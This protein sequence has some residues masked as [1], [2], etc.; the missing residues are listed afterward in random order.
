MRLLAITLAVLAAPARAEWNA[1]LYGGEAYTPRSDITLVVSRPGGSIDHTFHDVRWNNSAVY[2][3]RAGYW[4]ASAPWYGVGVDVFQYSADVPTQ[5]VDSTIQG[6]P[7]RATLQPIDFRITAVALDVLRL[8]YRAGRLEPY[9]AAGPVLFKVKV[10]NR[11]N[12]EFTGTAGRDDAWGYK[13]GAGLSWRFTPG[14]AIFGEY[15]FTH[16]HAEPALDGT[17]TGAK[18][19]LRFDLDSHH[20]VAGGSLRF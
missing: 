17:V 7:V 12:S 19:P 13:A 14:F 4:F 9:A 11:G 15:R 8:R 6:T 2:G 16:V 20:F 5:T 1:D 3:G 10:T 18:I